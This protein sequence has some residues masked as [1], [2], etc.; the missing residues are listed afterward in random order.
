MTIKGLEAWMEKEGWDLHGR[1]KRS[2]GRRM[3]AELREVMTQ[4]SRPVQQET[5]G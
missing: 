5:G 3:L 2:T 4:T 1:E